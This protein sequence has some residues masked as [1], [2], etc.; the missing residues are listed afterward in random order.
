MELLGQI[1][2][3]GWGITR[4]FNKSATDFYKE[5]LEYEKQ[6]ALDKAQACYRQA[7]RVTEKLNSTETLA[8]IHLDYAGLLEKQRN[9]I[10]A[11]NAYQH[12]QRY[13]L[14]ASRLEPDQLEVQGLL[15]NI[16]LCHSQYLL[17]QGLSAQSEQVLR[18]TVQVVK[19]NV[20]EQ[21]ARSDTFLPLLTNNSASD[22]LPFSTQAGNPEGKI[23]VQNCQ[24]MINAPVQGKNN[25]V[26]VHYYSPNSE[27]RQPHAVSLDSLRNALYQHYQLSNLSIQRI[28]GETAS[29]ED[30]YIN[31][32]IVEGQAQR[33]KDKEELKKKAVSFE[34]LPSS[35]RQQLEST[36][37]N[38]LI[39]LERLFEKQKLRDGSEGTPKRI[40]IQ[41]RAGIGKTTLCKKLV[42]DYQNHAFWQDQFDCVLWVPLRQLKT[43]APKRLEDL[44]CTQYFAGY[45]MSQAQALSKTFYTHQ[46][47]TLFILD[48]LDEVVGEL[49]DGRPLKDFLH[50]LLNQAHVVIT[51]RPAGVD[52]KLLGELDLELETVGFS[53]ANVQAY[54]EKFAPGPNQAAIQ[55]FINQTPLIQGLVNIPIQL[56][57]LCYSWDQIPQNK[58]VTMSTLY[59]AMVDKLWRKDSVRLEKEEKGKVLGVEVIEDLSESDLAELM[60]A[61]IDY[62]GYLAF[63]G[64]ETEKIEFSREELSQRRKE[65]NGSAQTGRKLPLNFTTNLKKTSYLH[66]ADAHRPE[67]ERQYHFLHLTFQEFFAAKFLAGH[68]QAYTKVE[69]SS[70]PVGQKDLS[71]M[72]QRHEVEAFIA[73]HKYNPRYE[74]V[75]W[76]VAGLLKGA[77]LENFFDVLEQ[78]PRDL[79]GGRHQQVLMGCLNEARSRLNPE[80]VLGLEKAFMRGFNFERKLSNGE[81]ESKLGRQSAFP[82]HLLLALLDQPD[83]IKSE[84]IN[85]LG[86]RP[87]LSEAAELEL[88]STL[89]DQSEN[90]RSAAATALERRTLSNAA[91]QALISALQDQNENVRSKAAEALGGQS[92]LSNTAVQ[93]LIDA[94]QDQNENVRSKAA[95]AL[96]GQSILSDTAVQALI[97]AL[98]DQNEN[99]RFKAT[100]ALGG[101]SILSDTAVQALISALQDQNENVRSKA[102]RA[103]R[104]QSILSDTAV[105]ALISALQDQNENVRSKAAEALG[106]QSILSDTAVQALIDA[107]QDQNENVRDAV[108]MALRGRDTLPKA[109]MRTIVIG[110]LQDQDADVRDAASRALGGRRTLFVADEQ[111]LIS[112][113]QDESRGLR[114]A[115][116]SWLEGPSTLSDAV[117]QALIGA[118][119]DEDCTVRSAAGRALEYQSTL[120]VVATQ[121]LISALQD[122]DQYVRFKAARALG[123]KDSLSEAAVLA[124]IEALQ[125]Q[126]SYEVSCIAEMALKGKSLLSNAAEQAL[127][128]ALQ[129]ENKEVRY[130]AVSTLDGESALSDATVHALINILQDEHK[131]T[132]F[133]AGIALRGRSTLPDAAVQ[134]LIGAL[135][136]ENPDIRYVVTRALD[137]QNTLSD[138]GVQA[139]IGAFEH[140]DTIRPVLARALLNHLED[141][142]AVLPGLSPNQIETLY[143]KCLFNYSCKHRAPLYV[144]DDRLHFYTERGAGQTAR[145]EKVKLE[146]I[147]QAFEAVQIK[148]GLLLKEA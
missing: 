97:D 144:Q 27:A 24:G 108:V 64:L 73:T 65:L 75:W 81:Y 46:A 32:A 137:S 29:L 25:T 37:L 132:G 55:Q 103:L 120:S 129:H 74:I 52:A 147:I 69:E 7:L 114:R 134:A 67:S 113:L 119:Q 45:E 135:Q 1:W 121:A 91:V 84:I 42:Y 39:A 43:H 100:G 115:V 23:V 11:G 13:A 125:D 31:L 33:E 107:L 8:R 128:G 66:T 93:A 57:A 60:T 117:V 18:E 116:A 96:G 22:S 58:T 21:N 123:S 2:R 51:S 109:A 76:M 122:Q 92:I 127:I 145:I 6:G 59:E 141:I 68:L 112:A 146:K 61:E 20:S 79:I 86:A 71:V 148:G 126:N 102:A 78:S 80:A 28:S 3:A 63:K 143:T 111:A 4:D 105:Q 12:A 124:L 16:G 130:R 99:V 94:L 44:L 101:Q 56:D 136:H 30:C 5:A 118:L 72:P 17:A 15:K 88:I 49:N 70:T 95:G 53:P 14:D 34:R 77:T 40:L 138:A 26:N 19:G 133:S 131:T 104:G 140:E 50:I 54:I 36:N 89:Q 98:Q 83:N 48:G 139:L 47:K 142:Y 10:E 87:T 85:A 106:G 110:A 41:G 35:E 62:L 90:I 82:E 9:M 38:K